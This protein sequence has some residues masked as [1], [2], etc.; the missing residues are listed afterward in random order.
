MPLNRTCTC[1]ERS[2][3]C[4]QVYAGRAN[5]E[6]SRGHVSD[7]LPALVNV[8][9][10]FVNIWKRTDRISTSS[11]PSPFPTAARLS[12]RIHLIAR[13]TIS[14]ANA[15]IHPHRGR[16]LARWA[17][18]LSPVRARHVLASMSIGAIVLVHSAFIDIYGVDGMQPTGS[19]PGKSYRGI[20]YASSTR[21]SPLHILPSSGMSP[22]CSRISLYSHMDWTDT[23]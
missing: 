1:R 10:A 17:A 8:L 21:R 9:F 7:H 3:T 20:H 4:I 18:N 12:D 22:A 15:S 16:R 23:R 19:S 2:C 5:D 14:L 6:R 11:S 13:A